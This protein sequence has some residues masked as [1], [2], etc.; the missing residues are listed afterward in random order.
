[1]YGFASDYHLPHHIVRPDALD[2]EFGSDGPEAEVFVESE[3]DDTRVAPQQ[4]GVM[5]A[6][7]LEAGIQHFAAVAFSTGVRK[8]GHPT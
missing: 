2:L 8:C 1:M 4:A 6:N 7:V 3:R 5:V